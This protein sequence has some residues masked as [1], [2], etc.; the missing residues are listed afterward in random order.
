[1]PIELQERVPAIEGVL[2]KT[3]DGCAEKWFDER[4]LELPVGARPG[5]PPCCAD[6]AREGAEDHRDARKAGRLRNEGVDPLVTRWLGEIRERNPRRQ[7]ARTGPRDDRVPRAVL[8]AAESKL[9][10]LVEMLLDQ[11]L[12]GLEKR[13]GRG[14]HRSL[15][16]AAA[17]ICA[18]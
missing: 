9:R 17:R 7:G 12:A 3:A 11:S 15:Q 8:E 5:R 4:D 16:A 13:L 1:M 6:P 14:A 18:A 2:A 10:H